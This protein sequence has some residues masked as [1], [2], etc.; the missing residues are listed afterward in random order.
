MGVPQEERNKLFEWSNRMIGIEDPEYAGQDNQAAAFELYAYANDLAN[1]RREEPK[2][3]LITRL[4]NAEII[5]DDGE[6]TV[7]NEQEID[8][9]MLLMAVAGNETTRNA[10]SQGLWALIEHPDQFDLL[11]SN[12]ADLID[13]AVD[14]IV[15]Y[16][17]PVLHFRRTATRDTEINGQKINAGEKVVMWH[18]SANRDE[19]EFENPFSLDVKRSP[20]NHVGFGG[21]GPHYCLGANLARLEL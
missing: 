15:R 19:S 9:F 13:T 12:T 16:A 14:E 20:N 4:I 3:D 17:S 1:K 10:T 21:G 11:K 5:G 7:L 18:I 6:P 8:G 2:D